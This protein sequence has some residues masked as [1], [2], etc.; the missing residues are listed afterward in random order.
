MFGFGKKAYDPSKPLTINWDGLT[1][2]KGNPGGGPIPAFLTAPRDDPRD[3]ATQIAHS[4]T[5][6]MQPEEQHAMTTQTLPG[7][8]LMQQTV[9]QAGYAIASLD[10]HAKDI[11]GELSANEK[12]YAETK[13]RLEA[14][15]AD[16]LKMRSAEQARLD[17]LEPPADVVAAVQAAIAAPIVP[18]A[19][20]P[21]MAPVPPAPSVAAT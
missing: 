13:A 1:D 16:V 5:N 19:V 7:K 15:L 9:E 20:E 18:P 3:L 8:T 14:E 11:N 17:V 21:V 10:Q 6:D 12:I 2:H 4:I